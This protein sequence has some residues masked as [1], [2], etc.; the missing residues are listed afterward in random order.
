MRVDE[1]AGVG[2]RAGDSIAIARD[3][4]HHDDR[5]GSARNRRARHDFEGFAAA[6]FGRGDAAGAHFS[7]DAQGS[8]RIR[9]ADGKAIAHGA[10]ERRIVAIGAGIP[11]EHTS[12]GAIEPDFF[13]DWNSASPGDPVDDT[14]ASFRK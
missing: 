2:G 7:H 4:L 14:G 6:N 12:G 8:R 10:G 13:N 3:V 11:G 9:G 1:L 5:V